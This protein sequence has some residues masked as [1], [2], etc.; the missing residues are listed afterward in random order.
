M[1]PA[2][3]SCARHGVGTVLATLWGDDGAETDYMLAMAML[4]IF[5]EAC[6]QGDGD[7]SADVD[8]LGAAL[9]RQPRALLDAMGDF[10]QNAEDIR[11]GKGLIWCDPLY[12]LLAPNGESWDDALARY[13]AAMQ[14]LSASD[15]LEHRFAAA[16]FDVAMQKA[17]LVRDL[18]PAYLAGDREYLG[19][20]VEERIPTLLAA[21]EDLRDLHRMLW[22][23]DMKRFGWEVMALRYG[24]ACGRLAD[25]ADEIGRYLSGELVT[26]EELDAEPMDGNRYNWYSHLASPMAEI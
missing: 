24:A 4:P 12:P 15:A 25:A 3:A 10:Y 13:D 16:C 19:G 2:L 5:S 14:T 9:T 23:R 8:A 20:V 7:H 18:R 22:E 21:Y 17:M 6:W 26:I 1:V 11:T